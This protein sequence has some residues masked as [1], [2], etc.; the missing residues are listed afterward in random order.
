[1]IVNSQAVEL[2]GYE[3]EELLG[4]RVEILVPDAF[5]S[6]HQNKRIRYL[7]QPVSRPMGAGL[8]LRARAADR[9]E[10]PCEVSLS[11][12]ETDNGTLALA[13][14]R[15]ISDRHEAQEELRDAVGRLRAAADVA[16]AVG[17]ETDLD[18][19]LETIVDRGRSLIEAR[20][21]MVLL[22]QGDEFVISAMAGD[23]D[24]GMRNQRVQHA[25]DVL[26]GVFGLCSSA[27]ALIAPLLFRGSQLG[28]LLAVD[29]IREGPGFG[30]E[31]QRLL[32]AFAASAATAVAT[33][34]T[35]AEE[36]LRESIKGSE[37]ERAHWAR[38]L[39]DETLQGL[40]GVHLTLSGAM[41]SGSPD[42][43]RVAAHDAVDEIASQVETLLG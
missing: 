30:E 25:S 20:A 26:W 14:I 11:A 12:M 5:R 27:S 33:A 41:R 13:A 36:R 43:V 7:K 6:N 3:R 32:E 35:V 29:R 21:L 1:M 31:D 17:A 15:D 16:A 42:K 2:F 19:V 24:K 18:R 34:K 37:H 10:F 9:R 4:H 22:A 40:A 8:D 28:T 23:V 39:H 38:E